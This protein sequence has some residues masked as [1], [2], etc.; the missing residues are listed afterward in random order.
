MV[1]VDIVTDGWFLFQ[2]DLS[3]FLTYCYLNLF[4]LNKKTSKTPSSTIK[5]MILFFWK[6]CQILSQLSQPWAQLSIN[7]TVDYFRCYFEIF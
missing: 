2:M 7:I 1:I 5:K 4:N 6:K 3:I